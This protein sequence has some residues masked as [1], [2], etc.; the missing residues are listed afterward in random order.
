[1]LNFKCYKKT[2][3]TETFF[4]FLHENKRSLIRML[5]C[6]RWKTIKFARSR[7]GKLVED[8]V[9]DKDFWKGIVTGLKG[10]RPLIKLNRMVGSN[11]KPTMVSDPK[12]I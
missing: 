1:M 6:D 8:V 2:D 5:A 11:E 3:I 12:E 4:W 7:D 9:V 10:A